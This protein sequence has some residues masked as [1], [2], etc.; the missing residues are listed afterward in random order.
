MKKATTANEIPNG[1]SRVTEILNPFNGLSSIDPCTLQKAAD[2]GTRV[3][4]YCEAHALGLFVTEVDED[5]KN[6]FEAFQ[7]WFDKMVTKVIMLE[8]R[9]NSD[10]YMLSGAFDML[11][12]L[13]GDADD[14]LSLVDIKTPQS[15]S[16]TWALQT[17]AY[18]MLLREEMA[19]HVDRRLCLML[20]KFDSCANVCEYKDHIRDEE[21]Y[22]MAL[23][24]YRYFQ[25]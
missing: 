21:L 4:A 3:H 7:R 23:R 1:Y 2:R 11:V 9:I 19:I 22:L 16:K 6:Y 8:T 24:L 5:C 17:A 13:K 12:V 10:K 14:C 20:P 25:K 18:K 15:P